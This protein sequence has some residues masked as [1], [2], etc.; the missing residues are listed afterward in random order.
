MLHKF[1]YCSMLLVQTFKIPAPLLT[2]YQ[3]HHL[4][5]DKNLHTAHDRINFQTYNG[6]YWN[7]IKKIKAISTILI[8]VNY[9]DIELIVKVIPFT[10]KL[11]LGWGYWNDNIILYH[12]ISC[13]INAN[14]TSA[15]DGSVTFNLSHYIWN[16]LESI[17]FHLKICNQNDTY[18]ND[19]VVS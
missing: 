12:H 5:Y 19:V 4:L 3:N 17:F 14:V 10:I 9:Y 11:I 8:L 18:M 15:F 1:F 2:S 7:V 16:N 6:I 13:D